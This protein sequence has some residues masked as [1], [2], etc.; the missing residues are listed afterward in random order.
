MANCSFM[1][2]SHQA[3][4][5]GNLTYDMTTV[6]VWTASIMRGINAQKKPDRQKMNW[7]KTEYKLAANDKLISVSV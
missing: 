4:G 3:R 6:S 2:I 5:A 7:H 1:V